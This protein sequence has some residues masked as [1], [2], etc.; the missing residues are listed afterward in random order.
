MTPDQSLR[1]TVQLPAGLR[2]V[3]KACTN[4]RDLVIQGCENGVYSYGSG[5]G[6]LG[7][8]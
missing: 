5:Q 1:H 7:V 3:R 6:I 2:T 8:I 4:G